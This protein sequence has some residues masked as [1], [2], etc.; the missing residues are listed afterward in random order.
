MNAYHQSYADAVTK[1][2]DTYLTPAYAEAKENFFKVFEELAAAKIFGLVEND[3]PC[4]E[5]PDLH[6]DEEYIADLD[7]MVKI[8]YRVDYPWADGWELDVKELKARFSH[9]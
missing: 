3:R 1:L 9:T 4:P 6:V 7:R 8:L 5:D 2:S